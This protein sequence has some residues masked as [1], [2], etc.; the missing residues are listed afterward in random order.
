MARQTETESSSIV[1]NLIKGAIA[2]TVGVLALDAVTELFTSAEGDEALERETQTR[3]DAMDPAHVLAN[4]VADAAGYE[5]EPRQPHTAGIETHY[6]IGVVPTMV[7]AAVAR[8]SSEI[9]IGR[10]LLFGTAMYLAQDQG[11]NYALG[12]TGRPTEYP[13]QAH[14]RGLMGHLAMGAASE[15]TLSAL[16]KAEERGR[17]MASREDVL[18]GNVTERRRRRRRKTETRR[19]S[20]SQ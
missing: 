9:N 15:G 16:D 4:R 13:W 6:G 11:L 3:P 20:G 10:G 2:G 14:M 12:L 17:E 5:L 1:G 19:R 18:E 7:Y 8:R